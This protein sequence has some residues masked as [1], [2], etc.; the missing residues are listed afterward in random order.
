MMESNT[1]QR[2]LSSELDLAKLQDAIN[3][4]VR[5]PPHKDSYSRLSR[6]CR[7]VIE[8]IEDK[9][10]DSVIAA[11]CDVLIVFAAEFIKAAQFGRG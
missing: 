9:M 7:S 2:P 6:Y 5:R 10:P 1:S 3:R 4:M 11:R 8:S